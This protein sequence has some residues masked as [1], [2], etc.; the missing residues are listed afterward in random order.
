M[1]KEEETATENE[2]SE[3]GNS[4]QS[5]DG[6]GIPD[7]P[8]ISTDIDQEEEYIDEDKYTTVTVEAM[9]VSKEG[10]YNASREDEH[11]SDSA[12]TEEG[13]PAKKANGTT[14]RVWT[15]EKPKPERPKKKKKKFRYESRAERK[16]TR[17]K[18]KSGNRKKANA[19]RTE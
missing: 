14:K 9:D 18:E 11:E 5:E 15:K 1:V 4:A 2:D 7:P 12:D 6:E 3:E 17:L 19:R 16:V 10:I 8:P 13:A